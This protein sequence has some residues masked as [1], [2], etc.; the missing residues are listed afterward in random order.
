M[1]GLIY[2][3]ENICHHLSP[4]VTLKG[5]LFLLVLF[6]HSPRICLIV[7]MFYYKIATYSTM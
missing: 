5:V 6:Y 1:R 4:S 7:S 3:L 2:T